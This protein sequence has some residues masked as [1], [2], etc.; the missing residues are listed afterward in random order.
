VAD[1]TFDSILDAI[2]NF[3]IAIMSTLGLNGGKLDFKTFLTN[4]V[5]LAVGFIVIILMLKKLPS[6]L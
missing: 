2:K 3:G 6:L 4:M 1:I 5:G